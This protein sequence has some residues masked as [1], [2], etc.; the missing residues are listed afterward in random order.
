MTD[1]NN[2][3]Q[4]EI[5]TRKRLYRRMF[6][7]IQNRS[8]WDKIELKLG[9]LQYRFTEFDP[10]QMFVIR[11]RELPYVTRVGERQLRI[12]ESSDH[13]WSA[14]LRH[15]NVRHPEYYDVHVTMRLNPTK[16][17]RM[18][19]ERRGEDLNLEPM[20]DGS[21]NALPFD[22]I[23]TS[24]SNPLD[25]A[26]LQ[27]LNELCAIMVTAP[28]R[29]ATLPE[30][31]EEDLSPS[32]AGEVRFDFRGWTLRTWEHYV[33]LPVQDSTVAMRRVWRRA[34][35]RFS[36]V[37]GRVY[38]N[39]GQEDRLLGELDRRQLSHSVNIKSTYGRTAAFYSKSATRV[40][41]EARWHQYR[42]QSA[43]GPNGEQP[44]AYSDRGLRGLVDFIGLQK[45]W[46]LFKF[47]GLATDLL[48]EPSEQESDAG[49]ALLR[50]MN[51]LLHAPYSQATK[52]EALRQIVETG[53]Y[54]AAPT[55]EARKLDR[56]LLRNGILR[57]ADR[58]QPRLLDIGLGE[59]LRRLDGRLA[60][61]SEG[62][63]ER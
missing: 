59:A 26:F 33:D 47:N 49:T 54:L 52:S 16:W 45:N 46:A 29:I 61:P 11:A 28:R 39:D 53:G 55:D 44:S 2:I 50:L 56:Y 12:H 19:R 4:S 32:V 1:T 40:R 38:S 31:V 14:R 36:N 30:G 27:A 24:L 21:S 34:Y 22:A 9:R 7:D 62:V 25:R 18:E 3:T 42:G 6:R 8:R 57:R 58:G 17:E 20:W 43:T 63:E 5:T 10:S 13:F 15:S 60:I 37:T 23:P 35:E 51:A 48:F 41:F